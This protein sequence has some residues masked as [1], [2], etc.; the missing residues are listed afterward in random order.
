MEL[1]FSM[2]WHEF[3]FCML[4]ARQLRE[5][6]MSTTAYSWDKWLDFKFLPADR[7][8]PFLCSRG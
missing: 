2:Y 6:N 3:C 7:P 8:L 5:Q 4:I 1:Q